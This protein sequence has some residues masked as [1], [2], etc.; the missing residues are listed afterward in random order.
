[1]ESRIPLKPVLEGVRIVELSNRLNKTE[2]AVLLYC[3]FS[4]F[5][6]DPIFQIIWTGLF[7]Y[8]KKTF[9]SKMY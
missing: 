3:R 4:L 2:S 6:K 5:L 9:L 7:R 8:D 1:M